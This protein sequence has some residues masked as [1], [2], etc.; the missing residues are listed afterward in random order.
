MMEQYEM[1]PNIREHSIRVAQVAHCLATGLEEA[2]VPLSY[3]LIITS[4][5]LH[6]IGKTACLHTNRDHS[7][8]GGRIC[9][10]HGFHSIADIVEEHVILKNCALNGSISET[11]I[12]YYADKRVNHDSVVSLQERLNYII[13]NYGNN[14]QELIEMIRKN[15]ALC[16]HIEEKIF[17]HLSYGPDDIRSCVEPLKDNLFHT[18]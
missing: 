1:L 9:R 17:N 2:G 4:A 3:E 8:L 10:D 5:L 11:I 18:A 12:V 6:D 13:G 16:R 15:Y 7:I 14:D